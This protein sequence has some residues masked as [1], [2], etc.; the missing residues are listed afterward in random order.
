ME[1]FDLYEG[2]L[3]QANI[4]VEGNGTTIVDRNQTSG[5]S[6]IKPNVSPGYYELNFLAT[7]GLGTK[8]EIL[9]QEPAY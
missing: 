8:S 9:T 1:A 7:D 3:T 4:T 2:A 5:V 6:S